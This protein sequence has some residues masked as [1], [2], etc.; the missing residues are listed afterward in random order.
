MPNIILLKELKRGTKVFEAGSEYFCSWSKYREFVETGY[1]DTLPETNKTE[2]EKEEKK[3]NKK[4][5][6]IDKKVKAE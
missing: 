2:A 3:L 6:K 1:C 5:S 4:E